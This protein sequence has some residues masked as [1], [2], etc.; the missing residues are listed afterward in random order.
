MVDLLKDRP[1][2]FSPDGEGKCLAENAES[3]EITASPFAASQ[4]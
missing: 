3:A 4:L 2:L 1:F